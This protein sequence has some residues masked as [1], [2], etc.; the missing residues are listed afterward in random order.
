MDGNLSGALVGLTLATKPEQIYR[1]LIE[2]TGF[3]LKW[4]VDTLQEGGVPIKKFVA[5]GGLPAKNP[6]LMQIYSD[7]LAQPIYLA[8]AT[9]SVAVGAAILGCLAADPK[10][11]GRSKAADAIAAMARLRSDL[12]FQPQSD[13]SGVYQQLYQIYRDLASAVGP[14]SGMMENLRRLDD[15]A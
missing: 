15:H 12:V 6:L 11:T 3:G 1:A 13:S 2:A 5:S 14:K 7:I 8:E 4:I 10:V 9:E